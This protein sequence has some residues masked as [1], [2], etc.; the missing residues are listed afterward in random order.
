MDAGWIER[1]R[2]G[3]FADFAFYSLAVVVLAGLEFGRLAEGRQWQALACVGAGLGAWTLLEYLIHRYVLHGVRPFS[4]WHAMH[5]ERPR[6]LIATPTPVTAA[7]F[8]VLVFLPAFE[9][10]SL[11][12][13]GALTLGI[14]AGFVAYSCAHHAV[15][16]VR[17]R[18]ALLLGLKRW[19]ALHH[20]PGAVECYGVTTS[21]WDHVFG[22]ARRGSHRNPP[23]PVQS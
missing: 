13:S 16:H 19:H 12:F 10:G 18:S 9:L 15:H 6:A 7:L 23:T 14:L 2:L 21:F 3:Y 20:R 4:R 22:T 17:G 1:S 11:W 8:A 5:H